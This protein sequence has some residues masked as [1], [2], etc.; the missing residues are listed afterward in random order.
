MAKSG[1]GA[2]SQERRDTFIKHALDQIADARHLESLVV[3]ARV[4]DAA[5]VRRS[6]VDYHFGKDGVGILED[7]IARH[8]G[9][10]IVRDSNAN[11]EL[12]R[13]LIE[14]AE[15]DASPQLLRLQLERALQRDLDDFCSDADTPKDLVGRERFYYL[16]IALCDLPEPVDYASHLKDSVTAGQA[17]YQPSYEEWCRVSGR[18]FIVDAERT[19]R[20]VYTYLEGVALLRRFDYAPDY[21]EIADTVLRIFHATTRPVDGEPIDVD[22]E[23]FGDPRPDTTPRAAHNTAD[24]YSRAVAAVYTAR[25]SGK[26]ASIRHASLH[27]HSGSPTTPAGQ[28]VQ[29]LKDEMDDALRAGWHLYR[30][31]SIAKADAGEAA[32]ELD[33]QVEIARERIAFGALDVKVV[34]GELIPMLVPLVIGDE[35]ALLGLDD[36]HRNHIAQI[37]EL[38]DPGAIRV[39]TDYFDQ[40]WDDPRM[41]RIA[42]P[43][44]ID[45]DGVRLAHAKLAGG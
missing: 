5:G 10:E 40:L 18:T 45:E 2:R 9:E 15:H 19:Q 21:R 44:G 28:E 20:A 22:A 36:R 13:Q 41:I 43:G 7:E 30:L 32:K 35:K 23:L 39:C 24:A 16:M 11:A 33:R 1:K 37:V 34:I 14:L 27:G 25:Q 6:T 31:V 8:V 4:G 42:G 29:L 38:A 12:Y 17:A 3:R 26:P